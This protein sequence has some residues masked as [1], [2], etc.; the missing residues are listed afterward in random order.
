MDKLDIKL[1]EVVNH[2]DI[3]NDFTLGGQRCYAKVTQVL[4]GDSIRLVFRYRGEFVR[5]LCR[6]SGYNA[7]ETRTKDSAEKACNRLL[8]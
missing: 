6:M 8:D 2:D 7:A 3:I 4:D 1:L 5:F